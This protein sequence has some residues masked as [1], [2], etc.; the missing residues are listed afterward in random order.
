MFDRIFLSDVTTAA[1]VS[2]ADDSNARTVKL[3]R[4]ELRHSVLFD[5]K[6]LIHVAE[7]TT[8]MRGM[9]VSVVTE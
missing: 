9:S 2:S 6:D 4:V 5:N 3:R 8:R 1:H 7:E